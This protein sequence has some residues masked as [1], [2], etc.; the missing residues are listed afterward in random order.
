MKIFINKIQCKHCGDI[1]E[2][3]TVHDFK[4]CECR[5]VFVDGGHE[6]LR[7]GFPTKYE[8][9]IIELSEYE[10]ELLDEEGYPTEESLEKI[11][12][13]EIKS[14]D[15]FEKLMDF[16]KKLWYYPDFLK[17]NKNKEYTLITGGWSGNEDIIGAM[18]NNI[19]LHITYWK[20][21]ERG[22]KHIYQSLSQEIKTEK[23]KK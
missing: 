11:K 15:D 18:K 22:G 13:W 20:S 2:S 23:N 8:D 6:Y 9:D 10:E 7:R 3:K 17:K 4:T 14:D 12:K 1:I 16:I 5:K 19:I 21:S